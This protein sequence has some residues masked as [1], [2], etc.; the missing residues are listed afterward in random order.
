MNISIQ[1]Y[2]YCRIQFFPPGSKNFILQY[3]VI[4]IIYYSNNLKLNYFRF[5]S[6]ATTLEFARLAD[7]KEE[8]AQ[9]KLLTRVYGNL[10]VCFNKENKP[11]CACTAIN[12]I[13]TPNA[14]SHFK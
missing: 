7:E 13:P 9:K 6:A 12:Q 2:L 4:N 1:N 3:Y 10:A 14:K 5:N 11:R 8:I